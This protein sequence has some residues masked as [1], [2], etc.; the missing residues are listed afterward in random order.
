MLQA[1]SVQARDGGSDVA[2]AYLE[3]PVYEM[4]QVDR[5]LQL[6]PGT[7]RRWIDGYRRIGKDYP[8][9]IREKKTGSRLVTWGE[10]VEA[11]LLSSYRDVGVPM[12]RMRPVVQALRDRFGVRYPLAHVR[13]YVDQGM[14]LVYEAQQEVQLDAGLRLVVEAQTGQLRLAAAAET[15]KNLVEFAY[16]ED[17]SGVQSMDE[18]AARLHPAGKASPVVIDPQRQFGRPVVRS[19]PT[20]VLAELVRAGD[21]VA[22]VACW[23]DLSEDEVNAAI[24]YENTLTAA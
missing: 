22:D 8:P 4:R 15:F 21:E 12:V 16:V 18:V 6:T 17:A 7:A 10:F 14:S 5:L 9:V 2:V 23:Y 20:E 3:R 13:P 19:V 24:A 1:G 11:R